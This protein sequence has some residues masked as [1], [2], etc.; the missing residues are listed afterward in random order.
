MF[1]SVPAEAI[2]CL[3]IFLRVRL[4]RISAEKGEK[5]KRFEKESK[6]LVKNRR[7]H[8][9]MEKPLKALNGYDGW[10]NGIEVN[11]RKTLLQSLAPRKS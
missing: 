1:I 10:R 2:S 3:K 9:N 5:K 6:C 11:Y 7:G 8:K 4:E